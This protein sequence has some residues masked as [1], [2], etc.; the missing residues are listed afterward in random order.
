MY[1]GMG[2]VL[3]V[4]KVELPPAPRIFPVLTIRL[5]EDCELIAEVDFAVGGKYPVAERVPD[6]LL[7]EEAQEIRER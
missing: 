4:R 3:S 1:F 2:D 6:W 5:G 7:R